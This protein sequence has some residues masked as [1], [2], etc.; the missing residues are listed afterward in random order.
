MFYRKG[1]DFAYMN[2]ANAVYAMF[3]AAALFLLIFGFGIFLFIWDFSQPLMILVGT[4]IQVLPL[5]FRDC[6]AYYCP[7][8]FQWHGV[9]GSA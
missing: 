4:Y 5:E 8:Y 2:T 9:S 7:L 3:A 1:P 6:F